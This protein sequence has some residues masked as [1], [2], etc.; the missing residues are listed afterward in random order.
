MNK[1]PPGKNAK[2]IQTAGQFKSGR[3]KLNKELSNELF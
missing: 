1:P 3:D 2:R